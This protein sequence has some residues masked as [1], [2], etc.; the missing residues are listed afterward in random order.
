MQAKEMPS[1]NPPFKAYVYED[2]IKEDLLDYYMD[3]EK[4]S[5]LRKHREQ[6]LP[7]LVIKHDQDFE[8]AYLGYLILYQGEQKKWEWEGRRVN[9]TA[10]DVLQIETFMNNYKK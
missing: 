4:K 2:L 8:K 6:S 9:L 5:L 3:E 7:A 1:L 10:D